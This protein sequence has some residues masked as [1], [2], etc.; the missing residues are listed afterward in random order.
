[1]RYSWVFAILIVLKVTSPGVNALAGNPETEPLLNNLF[2]ELK[3]AKSERAALDIEQRIWQAWYKSGDEDIDHLMRQGRIALG[4]RAMREALDVADEVVK[5]KPDYSEGWNFRATALFIAG[6]LDAS[7]ED[8]VKVLKLEP[9]HFGALSG[10]ALIMLRKGDSSAALAA[11][12]KALEI[13]PHL[14][15]ASEII[16]QAGGKVEKD[17]I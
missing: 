10:T 6:R 7:L 5:R 17:P 14:R 2:A 9:R 16:R 12:K 8:V 3:L 13:H 15:G 1:M 4:E 11:I